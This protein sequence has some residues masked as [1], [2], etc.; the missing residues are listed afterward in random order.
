MCRSFLN[1]SSTFEQYHDNTDN[2]IICHYKRDKKC[3]YRHIPK[4]DQ[5]N[6]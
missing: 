5:K 6:K 2:V 4:W 1:I 3:S